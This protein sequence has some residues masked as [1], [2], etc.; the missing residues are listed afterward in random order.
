MTYKQKLFDAFHAD[1]AEL[2]QALHKLRTQLAAGETGAARETASDLDRAAGAHIAFEENDFYPALKKALSEAEVD[3]MYREHAE[4]LA[5]IQDIAQADDGE[6]HD[7]VV[8]ASFLMRID[9]L[10]GHVADCGELFGAMGTLSEAEFEAL[11]QNLV[12]WRSH[13][14]RWSI[15]SAPETLKPDPKTRAD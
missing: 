4:G 11:Y 15:V 7:P 8:R 10:S 1:H 3:A 5:V 2:G 12:Y 13:A 14:P 6:L 9:A